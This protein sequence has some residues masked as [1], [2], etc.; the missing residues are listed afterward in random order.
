[1][2]IN[3]NS[4]AVDAASSLQKNNAAMSRSLSR[5]SSGMKIVKPSDDA[6]GLSVS[7]KLEAQSTRINA[8]KVNTQSAA[9]LVQTADGYLG[10]MGTILDRMSELAVMSKD[11]TK[12]PEDVTLYSNEFESLKDQLRDIVGVDSADANWET[13]NP[14]SEPSG[15]FNG[16]VLFGERDDMSFVVGTSGDQQMAISEINLREVGGAMADL[17]WDSSIGGDSSTVGGQ[18]NI[19]VNDAG[20]IQSLKDVL[21]VVVEERAKLGAVQSRL[22]NINAQLMIE[23]EN[24]TAANSRIRDVDVAEESTKLARNNI[25]IQSG[26]AMLQQANSLPDHVLR[27]LS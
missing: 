3:T 27:L 16:I 25:L 22:D 12:T 20:T 6:A 4:S 2:V 9:S 13:S 26:T 24:L 21:G 14:G 15:A 10:T 1:M 8:A 11:I 18:D 19:N 5:L 7:E 23:S 17:L